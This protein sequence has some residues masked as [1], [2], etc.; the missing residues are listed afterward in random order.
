MTRFAILTATAFAAA[1]LGALPAA[2]DYTIDTDA[3]FPSVVYV[4]FDPATMPKV[5]MAPSA[6][7]FGLKVI[8]GSAM[9][10]PTGPDPTSPDLKSKNDDSSSDDDSDD[11]ADAGDDGAA[12]QTSSTGT[13]EQR[14]EDRLNEVVSDRQA[15]EDAVI[16]FEVED[17]LREETERLLQ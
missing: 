12:D 4:N 16:D 14:A 3:A 5:V 2:A 17:R 8:D 13:F 15:L 10:A 1:T 9:P 11:N 7:D 6:S